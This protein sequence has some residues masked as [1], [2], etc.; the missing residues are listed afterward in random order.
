MRTTQRQ[1]EE[2]AIGAVFSILSAGST[3]AE[4]QGR[5]AKDTEKIVKVTEYVEQ[6]RDSLWRSYVVMETDQGNTIVTEQLKDGKVT[7][8][9]NPKFLEDRNSLAK[10]IRT[11]TRS[12]SGVFV[13]DMKAFLAKEQSEAAASPSK[14]KR[15]AQAAFGRAIGA[16][17]SRVCSG[18]RRNAKSDKWRLGGKVQR[19]ENRKPMV[20]RA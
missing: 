3:G 10:V 15:Y 4:K 12:N 17:V 20:R 11:A 13:A 7:W 19:A 9:E 16:A 8:E 14:C 1:G 2:E 18:F 5:R 6:A